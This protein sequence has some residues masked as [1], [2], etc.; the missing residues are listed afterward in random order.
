[1]FTTTSWHSRHNLP[2]R[3]KTKF[4]RKL[5]TF[6]K[7]R[8][9]IIPFSIKTKHLASNWWAKKWNTNLKNYTFGNVHL[10]KGKLH[11]RCEALA[12]LKIDSNYI[13]ASVLGSKINPYNVT[14]AVKPLSQAKWTKIR[15]LYDGHLESFEKIL[16]H[17]FPKKMSDIFSNKPLGLF[18]FPKDITFSCS[19]SDRVKICKHV[20]VVLYAIGAKIDENP[21]LLFELR[22]VNILEFISNSIH[23][24][25]KNILKRANNKNI[26]A[27]KNVNFQYQNT[28]EII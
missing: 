16:N 8:P 21:Q 1:M 7:K 3:L 27:L 4:R 11:F 25:R 22:G 13:Q 12:D 15:K 24:E 10:E 23:T 5:T 14:I 26:K 19:C 2:Y 6:Q 17:R 18:P 20:A 28:L 9:S